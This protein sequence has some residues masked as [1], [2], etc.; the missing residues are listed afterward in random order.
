M[1]HVIPGTLL[2]HLILGCN[3]I[4]IRREVTDNPDTRATPPTRIRITPEY[5]SLNLVL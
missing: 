1:R 5:R 4:W 3:A 2:I